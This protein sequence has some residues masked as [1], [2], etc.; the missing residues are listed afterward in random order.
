VKRVVSTFL[1][2]NGVRL[3]ARSVPGGERD[4][5]TVVVLHGF[6]G[7]TESM[8]GV[9]TELC[10]RHPV[11][12]IDFVGHGC[13]DAPDDLA[14]YSMEACV[15]QLACVFDELALERPHLLGYSMGGRAALSL[16][17]RHP[18]LARS[19]L[20]IGANAGLS[21]A[22]ARDARIRDDEALAARI[23]DGGLEAFVDDWMA[24]PLFASQARL[25]RDALARARAQRMHNRP[26]GLA[27]SLRGMGT[28]AMPPLDLV[29]IKVPLCFVVGAED[30]K[31]TVLARRY[32][33][34]LPGAR[35][36]VVPRA[37]HAA[38]LENPEVFGK[39]ARAFFAQV[40]TTTP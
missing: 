6:T 1:D 7:S 15:G 4:A 10:V 21:D 40:D 34:R 20:L 14:H 35:L 9:V 5:S 8:R 38:H 23:L 24:K 17:A 2:A 27:N 18:E 25:G 19:A 26:L 11:V 13:S 16:V 28:G 12:S 32:C 31:F 30:E 22:T 39:V 3:H 29:G 36:E 37:G 33:D